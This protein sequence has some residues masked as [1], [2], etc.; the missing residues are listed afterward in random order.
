M[1]KSLESDL[2]F[3]NSTMRDIVDVSRDLDNQILRDSD[4]SHIVSETLVYVFG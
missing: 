1:R 4:Y 3:F 2:D